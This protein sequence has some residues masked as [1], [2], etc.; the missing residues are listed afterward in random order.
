MSAMSC[1]RY[2]PGRLSRSVIIQPFAIASN[3]RP[4]FFR[5]SCPLI[6]GRYTFQVFQPVCRSH[7]I[8]Q[9]FIQNIEPFQGSLF[10]RRIL[11]LIR[12]QKH[13]LH[14][15]RYLVT[16]QLLMRNAPPLYERQSIFQHV[17][18]LH[19]DREVFML[20]FASYVSI[21]TFSLHGDLQVCAMLPHC[22]SYQ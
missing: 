18:D 12:K 14:R 3:H 16:E 7:E 20:L 10:A 1:V 17:D 2:L 15:I 4:D 11:N 6:T 22:N 21:F 5:S 8:L 9:S 19:P 13:F